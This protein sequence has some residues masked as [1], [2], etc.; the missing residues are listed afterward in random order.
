VAD[1]NGNGVRPKPTG[2]FG[3]LFVG[4]DREDSRGGAIDTVICK[5][6]GEN[7]FC[8][9]GG[10]FDNAKVLETAAAEGLQLGLD[11]DGLG[12]KGQRQKK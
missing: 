7:H 2:D 10:L 12:A 3:L 6:N 8:A 4:D 1:A 9:V 11:Q 5:I